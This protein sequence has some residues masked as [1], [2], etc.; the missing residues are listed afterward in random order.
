[1]ATSGDYTKKKSSSS[2][3]AK[4]AVQPFIDLPSAAGGAKIVGGKIA[5]TY[6]GMA[7]AAKKEVDADV[8][9][10]HRLYNGASDL[11]NVKGV[12]GKQQ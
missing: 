11:L 6:Q 5:K 8:D 7:N 4:K 9:A 2:K 1:M 10:A 12:F 3:P